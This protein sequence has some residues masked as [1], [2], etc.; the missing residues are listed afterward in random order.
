M[1]SEKSAEPVR[2]TR[3]EGKNFKE[4]IVLLWAL[5]LA[6]AFLETVIVSGTGGTRVSV[7]DEDEVAETG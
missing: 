6:S 5:Q 7:D 2:R 1:L 3:D 4:V